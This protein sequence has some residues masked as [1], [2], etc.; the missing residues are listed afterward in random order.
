MDKAEELNKII[1]KEL[2][3]KQKLKHQEEIKEIVRRLKE[4]KGVA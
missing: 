1:N 2:E 4:L 3:K